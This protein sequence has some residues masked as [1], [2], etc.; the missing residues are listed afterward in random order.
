MDEHYVEFSKLSQDRIIGTKDEVA[1][2]SSLLCLCFFFFRC[3][4]SF[5]KLAFSINHRVFLLFSS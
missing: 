1:H 4:G 2:V 5:D 3:K